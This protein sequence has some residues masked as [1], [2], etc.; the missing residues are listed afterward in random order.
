[1]ENQLKIA[2]YQ[3]EGLLESGHADEGYKF[4]ETVRNAY[5]KY[6]FDHNVKIEGRAWRMADEMSYKLLLASE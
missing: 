1:M 3:A 4:L 5:A 6:C 2:V